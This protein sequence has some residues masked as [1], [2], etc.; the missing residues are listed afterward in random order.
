MEPRVRA[1]AWL[2]G[3]AGVPL[4]PPG[5]V[6]AEEESR[7]NISEWPRAEPWWAEACGRLSRVPGRVRKNPK[8]LSEDGGSSVT[9]K[10]ER[11]SVLLPLIA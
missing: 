3:W 4:W 6:L 8:K 11:V 1:L 10:R 7:V 2:C 9:L 5:P